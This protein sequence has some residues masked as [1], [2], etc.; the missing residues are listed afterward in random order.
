VLVVPCPRA[1]SAGPEIAND[2]GSTFSVSVVVAETLPQVPVI[3]NL[4]VPKGVELLET[5]VRVV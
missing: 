1:T 4:L 2:G 5:S 3:F